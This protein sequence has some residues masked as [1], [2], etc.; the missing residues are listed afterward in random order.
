MFKRSFSAEARQPMRTTQ[1]AIS[2]R[3]VF[4]ALI[5]GMLLAA[6]P[7]GA[8]SPFEHK[9]VAG[10]TFEYVRVFRYELNG[11]KATAVARITLD[12]VQADGA[13]TKLRQ[14]IAVVGGKTTHRD[15]VVG[16]N[17]RWIY[18]DEN[19][20]AQD[21]AGYDIAQFGTLPP[22]V[23]TGSTWKVDV[24]TT[25][26][27][28]SGH[29]VIKVLGLSGSAA[30]LESVGRSSPSHDTVMDSDTHKAVAVSTY[31]NWRVTATLRDG[32]LIS[33]DRTDTQHIRLAN[34][35]NDQHEYGASLKL[36]SHTLP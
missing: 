14:T 12:V 25:A 26:M 19:L 28:H 29:A 8:P 17:G 9:L 24:P 2:W 13:G 22:D 34:S 11:G 5:G 18:P 6:G 21:F 31:V 10:E 27:F 15:I 33:F 1:A 32:I 7:P 36:V 20:V 30:T 4:V 3:Q 23:R 16:S 35:F